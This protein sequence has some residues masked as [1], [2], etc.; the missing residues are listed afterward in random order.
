MVISL[1]ILQIFKSIKEYF[2]QVFDNTLHNLNEM[3][4]LFE[5][6]STKVHSRKSNRS[7][8]SLHVLKKLIL[9]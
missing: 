8:E 9:H 4:K 1:Q 6:Q 2:E 3:N 5:R 7:L